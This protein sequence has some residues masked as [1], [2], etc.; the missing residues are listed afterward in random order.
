MSPF[1]KTFSASTIRK[2]LPIAFRHK[3]NSF[4]HYWLPGNRISIA[5]KAI[6]Q[7]L[8]GSEHKKA[9]TVKSFITCTPDGLVSFV[10][11][12]Y[13]GRI[14]DVNL[15]EHSKFLDNLNLVHV[16]PPIEV[17][18]TFISFTTKKFYFVRTSKYSTKLTKYEVWQ[19]EQ[20]A[21]LRIHVVGVIH[22]VREFSMLTIH[23]VINSNLVGIL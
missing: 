11:T 6:H 8:T 7:A 3:Y 22:R 14:I 23:S 10:S 17:S 12:E 16:Y 5:K 4:M 15:V 20:I 18:S 13:G 2:N 19:N 9:N 21:S 1:V